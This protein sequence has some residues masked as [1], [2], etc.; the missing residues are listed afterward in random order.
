MKNIDVDEVALPSFLALPKKTQAMVQVM[1]ERLLLA[2]D[3]VQRGT[4]LDKF[5]KQ[6]GNALR[7]KIGDAKEAA[8]QA[9]AIQMIV[10]SRTAEMEAEMPSARGVA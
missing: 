6:Y 8:A 7:E 5:G 10:L 3:P 9:F 2:D 4:M 1:A